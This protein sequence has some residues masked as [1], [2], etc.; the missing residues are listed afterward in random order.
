ML[1]LNFL[2]EIRHTESNNIIYTH[3]RA[4]YRDTNIFHKI[5]KNKVLFSLFRP[6]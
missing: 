1:I 3:F 4:F 6:T 2:I 5:T